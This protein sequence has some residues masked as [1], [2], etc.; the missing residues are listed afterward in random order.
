[1]LHQ[2][3]KKDGREG[4]L[5]RELWLLKCPLCLFPKWLKVI[6]SW[7]G[8]QQWVQQPSSWYLCTLQPD[9][10]SFPA[11]NHESE[12]SALMCKQ[13]LEHFSKER[14]SGS[15]CRKA[16]IICVRPYCNI[17]S[18]SINS[19]SLKFQ[20]KFEVEVESWFMGRWVALC[21]T[22][23]G[24]TLHIT[25]ENWA[26]GTVFAAEGQHCRRKFEP[27]PDWVP[28]SENV[29]KL[30]GILRICCWQFCLSHESRPTFSQVAHFA[31]P[32]AGCK[33]SALRLKNSYSWCL[34]CSGSD[35]CHW[36]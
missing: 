30:V 21:R 10:H 17:V 19:Q 16:S 5:R 13:R 27:R 9:A 22:W 15:I 28:D 8:R 18:S 11:E 24:L 35:F 14:L 31:T 1:M 7:Q 32:T 26:T 2:Q 25:S 20:S 33:H 29:Q 34:V 3:Q 4:P 6:D 36:G 12:L 23:T